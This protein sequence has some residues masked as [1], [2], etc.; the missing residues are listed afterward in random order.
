[1]AASLKGDGLLRTRLKV[2]T[3]NP[4]PVRL[5]PEA[6]PDICYQRKARVGPRLQTPPGKK[7]GH[8]GLTYVAVMSKWRVS[9]Y[10]K[11][12]I[13]ITHSYLLDRK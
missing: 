10:N 3:A 8:R 4:P 6:R 1:M 12:N 2:G 13:Y 11:T 7:R 5:T 9:Y